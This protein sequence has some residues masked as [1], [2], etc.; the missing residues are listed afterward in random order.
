MGSLLLGC[1]KPACACAELIYITFS[2]LYAHPNGR[3]WGGE[4]KSGCYSS[5]IGDPLIHLLCG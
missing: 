4:G 1:F 2:M 3:E 5:G